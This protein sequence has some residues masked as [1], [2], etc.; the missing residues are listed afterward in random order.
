MV[1]A[2]FLETS[3]FPTIVVEIVFIRS[4]EYF[5]AVV[6]ATSYASFNSGTLANK[7][8]PSANPKT[9]SDNLPK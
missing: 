9:F 6:I 1:L 2:N 5:V 7:F 3:T 8:C 4:F